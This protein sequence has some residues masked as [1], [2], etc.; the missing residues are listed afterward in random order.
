[1]KVGAIW[2]ALA[3]EGD[4][5]VVLLAKRKGRG[6]PTAG[7]PR[8][9]RSLHFR[10]ARARAR[11]Y[12]SASPTAAS[13]LI[14][15]PRGATIADRALAEGCIAAEP[16]LDHILMSAQPATF[17]TLSS[18]HPRTRERLVRL[19]P[20]LLD[21]PDLAT[22]QEQELSSLLMFLPDNKDIAARVLDRL[23]FSDRK[24][25]A[26]F[27]VDRFLEM[28][29]D[30]VFDVLVMELRGS[31]TSVPR[32]WPDA[33]RERSRAFTSRVLERGAYGR[34]TGCGR[35][36]DKPVVAYS[37]HQDYIFWAHSGGAARSPI[38]PFNE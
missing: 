7:A 36:L 14:R 4:L 22:L 3:S 23:L 25:A 8:M 13:R 35:G 29:Q 37:D 26:A 2:E 21:S 38:S 24:A 28:T 20:E 27:F 10:G 31:G 34:A 1:L 9:P 11:L 19:N 5:L 32:V 12:L 30:R 16:L 6:E 15:S 18:E 33:V 17:L